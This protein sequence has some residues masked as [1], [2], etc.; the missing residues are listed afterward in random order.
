MDAGNCSTQGP[1]PQ[2]PVSRLRAIVGISPDLLPHSLLCLGQGTT[3][4]P[5]KEPRWQPRGP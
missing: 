2:E 3:A 5:W 4:A 1:A